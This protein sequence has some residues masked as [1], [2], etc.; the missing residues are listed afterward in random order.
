MEGLSRELDRHLEFNGVD[1]KIVA[2]TAERRRRTHCHNQVKLS[3]GKESYANR[4]LSS[5]AS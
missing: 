1:G 2:D 3:V 4:A 5:E